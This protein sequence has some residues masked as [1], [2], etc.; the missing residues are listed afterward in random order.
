M[1]AVFLVED[2]D[3]A[4]WVDKVV[5]TLLLLLRDWLMVVL[6]LYTDP[7]VEATAEDPAS[8]DFPRAL[9]DTI[10][11]VFEVGIEREREGMLAFTY[12]P[13]YFMI[14]LSIILFG[15]CPCCPAV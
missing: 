13:F 2:L 11:T 8:Q 5:V 14:S 15:L 4:S 6:P 10:K 3:H 1:C 9:H 7:E 12:S